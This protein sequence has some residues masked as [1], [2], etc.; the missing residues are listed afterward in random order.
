MYI[1]CTKYI[2][3]YIS[4]TKNIYTYICIYICIYEKKLYRK[5]AAKEAVCV[6]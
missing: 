1:S 2:Y 6:Q 5:I 3:T 4:C